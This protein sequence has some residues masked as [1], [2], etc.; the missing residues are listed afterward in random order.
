MSAL[1]QT[2]HDGA[3]RAARPLRAGLFTLFVGKHV[4][5][6]SMRELSR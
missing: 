4:D 3:R 1:L 2:R 6:L 5:I